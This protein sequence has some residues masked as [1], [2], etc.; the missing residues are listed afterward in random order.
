MAA[1]RPVPLLLLMAAGA[2]SAQQ[3]FVLEGAVIDS[4][5][6]ANLGVST[7]RGEV[8]ALFRAQKAL[9]FGILRAAGVDLNSLAPELR[10]RI[11]R[12]QTTNLAAFRAYSDGLDLKDQ[13]RF[14]E[15]RAQFQR[16]AELD[17]AFELA[18]D[19]QQAMPEVTLSA[20][21]QLRAVLAASAGQAVSRGQASYVV[22]AQRAVAAA[23]SGFV[24]TQQ[25][26]PTDK[27]ILEKGL[28]DEL[29]EQTAD[30]GSG[31]SSATPRNLGTALALGVA[32]GVRVA[33]PGE[34]KPNE[35]LTQN[36]QLV[37][38]AA[39][40]GGFALR[41]DGATAEP[42]G[43]LDLADGSR[44]Y[45][46]RWLSVP[47]ASAT[48]VQ[49]EGNI[50]APTLG[51]VDWIAGDATRVM[52]GSGVAGFAPAGG[53]NL[54][55]VNGRIAVDFQLRSVTLQN[56]GFTLDGLVFSGL[57][58]TASYSRESLSGLFSGNYSAGGCTGCNG[59]VPGAS[60]FGGNFLGRNADGMLFSTTLVTDGGAKGGITVLRREP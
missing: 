39:Q 30:T 7:E 15:A 46:G 23:Q 11:E 42:G 57:Q 52:P 3:S 17:P 20:Q 25:Q 13:G 24:V 38:V 53:G 9:T 48:L 50:G 14:A 37:S 31:G 26:A 49:R 36:G 41:R 54:S 58:G 29:S 8:A 28:R 43:S 60:S 21:V 22:D 59:F 12:F 55:D 35:F 16:A 47:G 4:R 10:A 18:R 56:L 33:L 34:W 45:W 32:D 6:G 5:S 2:A 44:V 1:P 19:Q 27:E 40:S 51:A